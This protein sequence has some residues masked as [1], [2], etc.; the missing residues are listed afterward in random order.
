MHETINR[1]KYIFHVHESTS[2]ISILI[3]IILFTTMYQG[4]FYSVN[5]GMRKTFTPR[6]SI[7]REYDDNIDLISNLDFA[8]LDPNGNI[9][10]FEKN[11]DWITMVSPGFSLNLDSPKTIMGLDFETRRSFYQK[12]SKKGTDL[13]NGTAQWEQQLSRN[14]NL[15]I[16]DTFSRSND[17]ILVSEEGL[18]EEVVGRRT[19]YRNNGQ[20]SL[21]MRFGVDSSFVLGYRNLYLKNKSEYYEDSVS[22]DF[23]FNLDTRFNPFWGIG[24]ESRINRGRFIPKI[25]T[26][27][28]TENFYDREGVITLNYHW[29]PSRSLFARY[30]LLGKKYDNPNITEFWLHQSSAGLSFTLTPYTNFSVEGGYFLQDLADNHKEEGAKF[31]IVLNTEK[32]RATISLGGS[33]GYTQDYFSSENL[34][35]SKFKRVLGSVSYLLNK[36]L[37]AF[38]SANYQW[39]EFLEE[40]NQANRKD[41][42][43]RTSAR[44]NFSFSDWLTLSIEGLHS[45]RE[46]KSDL[47]FNRHPEFIRDNRLM[48]RLSAAHPII[49]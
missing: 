34:G 8:K 12:N 1:F 18:I 6:I 31:N 4:S 44:F 27:P 45:E 26:R 2:L 42:V 11:S 21:S 40:V 24:L 15:E 7:Y 30:S 9:V 38:L 17:P 49:F 28:R 3:C 25:Y 43:W 36:D 39:N 48:L 10:R 23:F 47:V 14:L 5:A 37:S 22:H 46:S 19:Y 29:H 13:H 33:G 35:S 20:I 41:E 16:R 32:K